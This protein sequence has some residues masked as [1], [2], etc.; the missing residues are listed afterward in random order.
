MTGFA[1]NYISYGPNQKRIIALVE[2]CSKDFSK[3]YGC[4]HC[5]NLKEC[6]RFFDAHCTSESDISEEF[7][8]SCIDFF[9]RLKKDKIC[10]KETFCRHKVKYQNN[11]CKIRRK[12]CKYAIYMNK[13][14][15]K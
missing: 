4:E 9:E 1:Q 12:E 6:K 15:C 8:K 11:R 5:P 13:G 2:K 7:L 10:L 3:E 14:I